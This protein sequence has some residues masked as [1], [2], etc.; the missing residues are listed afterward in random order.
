M[1]FSYYITK[2]FYALAWYVLKVF[3]RKPKHILYCES[4][5]DMV[6][7]QNVAPY[8][9]PIDI[10][11]KNK[12]VKEEIRKQGHKNIRVLPSFP[13]TVIMF[14]N[15]AWKFP[16]KKIVKIGFTHG[17]Y[18]FKRHSKSEYYNM[19]D[20]FFMTSSKDIEGV[21]KLG[22]TCELAVAFPKIDTAFDIS[23]TYLKQIKHKM[24]D[25][26]DP[27]KKTLLFSA[28][29]DSSGMSAIDKWYDR[30]SL[31]SDKYNLLVT[32]HSWMNPKYITALKTNKDVYFIE[33]KLF[34]DYIQ[35]SDICISD[36]SSVIAEFCLLD[37][38]VITFTVPHTTRTMPDI[39]VLIQK[40]SYQIDTFEE[41]E[42]AIDTL[43]EHPEMFYIERKEAVKI[44]FDTPDGKSG[45]RAAERICELVP[46]LR[47]LLNAQNS[48]MPPLVVE[49]EVPPFP[50][51]KGDF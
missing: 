37:K 51:G 28:T 34:Y 25:R 44:M 5:F 23:E 27:N 12:A 33:E 18:S 8:L 36:S 14:R 40:V 16:C 20:L 24:G 6:L 29:W 22:V 47:P 42:P 46:G 26:Y 41:I 7:F 17:A 4:A 35:L 13:D 31:L 45:Q 50:Q 19:F 48:P 21:R 11:A 1:V 30:I 38:P 43:F 15:M 2:P 3:R 49:Q 10:V 9:S 39:V 32:L